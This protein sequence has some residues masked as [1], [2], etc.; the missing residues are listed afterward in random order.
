MTKQ[1]RTR[2]ANETVINYLE[3]PS[4]RGIST[5]HFIEFKRLRELY[6]SQVEEKS[7]QLNKEI[8]PTSYRALMKD[9]DLKTFF[10]AAWI[11]ANSIEEISERQIKQCEEY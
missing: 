9:E 6:K 8:V 7:R 4:V 1:E 10:A 11:E 5:K 3:A 2:I